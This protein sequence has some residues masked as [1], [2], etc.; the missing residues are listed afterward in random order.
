[1]I[2]FDVPMLGA[3]GVDT[4]VGPA[5]LARGWRMWP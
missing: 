2:D 5:S 3:T 1:V 4:N